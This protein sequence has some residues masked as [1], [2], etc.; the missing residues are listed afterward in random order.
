MDRTHHSLLILYRQQDI[1]LIVQIRRASLLHQGMNALSMEDA[2]PAVPSI[3]QDNE[4][5]HDG[6]GRQSLAIELL[7][8][9]QRPL[10]TPKRLAVDAQRDELIHRQL[11]TGIRPR[12]AH[13]GRRVA[14][15]RAGG[16]ALG[17]ELHV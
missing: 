11:A 10:K 1:E 5:L 12:R 8:A 2:I 7:R 15:G 3:E 14:Q 9:T 13:Q 17:H 4:P 16:Q 6:H